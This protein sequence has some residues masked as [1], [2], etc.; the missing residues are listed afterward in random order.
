MVFF[1]K[2]MLIPYPMLTSF[3]GV[4]A[5]ASPERSVLRPSVARPASPS[6][7]TGRR[8]TGRALSTTATAF[9]VFH[10]SFRLFSI[11]E[12]IFLD[13]EGLPMLLSQVEQASSFYYVNFYLYN[14]LT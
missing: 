9:Q 2:E 6:T 5:L 12:N 8:A 1:N 7:S 14:D 3:A 10:I 4:T 13:D 11:L